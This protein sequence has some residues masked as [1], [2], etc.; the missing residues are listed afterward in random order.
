MIRHTRDHDK[1]PLR[2][3]GSLTRGSSR[4]GGLNYVNFLSSYSFFY[5]VITVRFP[6]RFSLELFSWV[7]S[8]LGVSSTVGYTT[9]FGVG[10][11]EIGGGRL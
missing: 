8:V 2:W 1:P 9:T 6:L 5:P 3:Q 7:I 11:V 4:N 10:R